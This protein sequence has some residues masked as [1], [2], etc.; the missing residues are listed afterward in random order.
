ML[1]LFE[2]ENFVPTLNIEG[3]LLIPEFKKLVALDKSKNKDLTN[4]YFTFLFLNKDP[5]SPHV[6]ETKKKRFES[7]LIASELTTEDVLKPEYL[8]AEKKFDSLINSN[9]VLNMISASMELV[10]TLCEHY[11]TVSFDKYIEEGPH[12]GQRIDQ[13]YDAVKM[14]KESNTIMDELQNLR[15]VAEKELKQDKKLNKGGAEGG[16]IE[17]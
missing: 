9:R 7:A 17:W 6:E 10:D 3:I 8:A 15:K 16:F 5:M 1:R 12:R 14:L 2:Y 11:R 13:P 4:R